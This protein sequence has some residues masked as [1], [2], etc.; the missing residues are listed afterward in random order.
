MMLMFDKFDLKSKSTCSEYE[1]KIFVS[2]IKLN[3]KILR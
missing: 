3:L 2:V 1:L